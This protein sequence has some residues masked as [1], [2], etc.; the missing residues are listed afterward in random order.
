MEFLTIILPFLL[1]INIL[2]LLR[3]RYERSVSR[4]MTL[5]DFLYFSY[6]KEEAMKKMLDE[7][8]KEIRKTL[9]DNYL[10]QRDLIILK[11]KE[12]ETKNKK[13]I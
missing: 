13:D 8:N 11:F 1:W 4:P 12:N 3:D 2:I 6:D 7:N 9:F 5:N 10:K